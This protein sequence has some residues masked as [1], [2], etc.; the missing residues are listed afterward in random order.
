MLT[1]ANNLFFARSAKDDLFEPTVNLRAKKFVEG[2]ILNHS[3]ATEVMK[4]RTIILSTRKN[5]QVYFTRIF[6]C[7]LQ[8]RFWNFIS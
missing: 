8:T 1:A 3:E 7:I 2:G 4:H 6:E 5:I